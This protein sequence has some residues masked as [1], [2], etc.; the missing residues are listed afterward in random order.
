MAN[1]SLL[2]LEGNSR[3][4]AASKRLDLSRREFLQFCAT[5]AAS[6]GLPARC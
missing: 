3:I 2:K 1:T 5:I 6:L 4:A